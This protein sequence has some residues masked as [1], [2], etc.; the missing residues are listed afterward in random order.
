MKHKMKFR[1]YPGDT[2]TYGV[3]W[4]GAYIKWLEA[5]RVELF[6]DMGILF[7]EM[8]RLGILIPVVELDIRYK[9]VARAFEELFVETVIEEFNKSNVVFYQEIKNLQTGQLIL[10][11]R[12]KNVTTNSEGKLHRTVPD[13]LREKYNEILHSHSL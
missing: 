5:S 9:H 8:D 4:H 7:A 3:V 13:Y 2:D 10:T 1:V 12:V 6:E 11:A